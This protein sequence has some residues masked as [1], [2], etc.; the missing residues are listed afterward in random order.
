MPGD[1]LR[2]GDVDATVEQIA[3]GGAPKIVRGEL[4]DLDA[5]N[6]PSVTR[7]CFTSCQKADRA[8]GIAAHGARRSVSCVAFCRG[9]GE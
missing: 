1:L 3:N 8:I 9:V 7:S 6:A 2:R 4:R 5:C